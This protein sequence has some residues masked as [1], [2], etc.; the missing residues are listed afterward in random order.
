MNKNKKGQAVMDFLATYGWAIVIVLAAIGALAYFNVFDS[1]SDFFP[2]IGTEE[3]A[4]FVC[5]NLDDGKSIYFEIMNEKINVEKSLSMTVT[6]IDGNSTKA[7]MWDKEG[8]MCDINAE[9][10]ASGYTFCMNI[11]MV[12]PVNYTEFVMWSDKG[13]SSKQILDMRQVEKTNN[14]PESKTINNISKI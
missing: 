5:N 12:V 13:M 1:K 6:E 4:N 2:D 3:Y 8:V 11:I 7:R 9:V 14:V 10:C